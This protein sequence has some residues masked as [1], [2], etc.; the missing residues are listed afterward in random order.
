MKARD[1][2]IAEELKKRLSA[3]VKLVDFRVFGS[4]AWGTADE[5]SDMDIFLEVESLDR[6]LKEQL[7]E[8]VW[9]VG[10]E[11]YMVISPLIFTR[12]EIEDSPL[13]SSPIVKSIAEEGVRI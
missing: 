4:R 7:Q 6:E 11:N 8:I 9:E 10:F 13:R 2:Q 1:M 5:Y 12:S 3:A